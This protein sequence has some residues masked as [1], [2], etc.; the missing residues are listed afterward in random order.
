MAEIVEALDAADHIK[1]KP[2]VI[3]ANTVK[4]KGVS[5]AENKASFHNGEL[6]EEQFKQA[7]AEIA[8]C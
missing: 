4:G 2:L 7:K 5:F 6:T 3:I 8:N 1:G